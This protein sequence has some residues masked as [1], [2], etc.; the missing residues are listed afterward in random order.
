MIRKVIETIFSRGI[1][2]ISNFLA[3]ILTAKFLGAELRGEIVILLLSVNIV[4]LFQVI[5][6]GP[7]LTFFTPKKSI[8]RLFYISFIWSIISTI[9]VSAGLLVTNLADSN[10]WFEL[11]LISFFQGIHSI[12]QGILLGK[13]Q[14]T[15]QNI[16]EITKSVSAI[17]LIVYFIGIAHERTVDSIY[18]SYM[19]SFGLSSFMGIL[20]ILPYFKEN[21]HVEFQKSI[22]LFQEL[23]KYG[24][25]VQ[26]NNISQM[27]NYRFIFY[28][29]EKWKG[30][31]ALGIFSVAISIG[32]A[33][34]IICKSIANYQTARIVNSTD[35]Y[36]QSKLTVIS[37]KLSVLLT[38]LAVLV[39]L[40][41]PTGIYTYLFGEEFIEIKW[42][43][44][45][46]AIGVISLAFFT[47]FNHYF[48]GTDQNWKNI[49]T[50]IIGNAVTIPVGMYLVDRFGISGGAWTYS[51]VNLV[52]LIVLIII[53]NKQNHFSLKEYIPKFAD[54][55][56]LRNS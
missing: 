30:N 16:L 25:Q 37:A 54:I 42:I 44:S 41:L 21:I 12:S 33:V 18:L 26:F 28:I 17:L 40:L 50:T 29:I 14:I 46:F 22:H 34:W 23:F 7:S 8:K 10:L 39:L 13:Q 47:I 49:Y 52:M 20:F 35:R 56:E 3:V 36:L 38:S 19:L 24:V 51:I 31:E 5:L 48:S 45:H 27:V 32:E 9:I 11:I 43:L 6:A 55:K 4:N 1:T 53:F 2:A 15:K